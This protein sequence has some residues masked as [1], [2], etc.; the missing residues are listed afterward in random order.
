MHPSMLKEYGQ[1]LTAFVH[2]ELFKQEDEGD[3]NRV[4]TSDD[5]PILNPAVPAQTN[6]YDCG[7]FLLHYVELLL[8]VSLTVVPVSQVL[9]ESN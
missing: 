3:F 9:T 1:L 7:I 8:K 4:L 5:L 2:N 6:N